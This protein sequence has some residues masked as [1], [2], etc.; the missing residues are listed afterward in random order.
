MVLI[1]KPPSLQ[2]AD[3]LLR[4]ARSAGKPVVVDFIGYAPPSRRV[5]NLL[6]AGR[7]ISATHEA[8]GCTRPTV[9]CMITGQA[10]GTAAALC[11]ATG[12]KP[13]NFDVRDLRTRLAADGAVL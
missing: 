2:V 9:Q 10:A 6:L 7:C 5:D 4:V 12:A 11:A 1:S 8:S 3:D 13:R